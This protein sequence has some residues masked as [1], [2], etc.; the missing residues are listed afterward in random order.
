MAYVSLIY[1]TLLFKFDKVAILLEFVV[2]F[3]QRILLLLEISSTLWELKNVLLCL[4]NLDNMIR[5]SFQEKSL[6]SLCH[7]VC[8]DSIK[9]EAL[10][11]ILN[12]WVILY[13]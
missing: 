10:E 4:L 6:L 2:S 13:L 12:K 5:V 8:E 3:F 7:A 1:N 11:H 9:K